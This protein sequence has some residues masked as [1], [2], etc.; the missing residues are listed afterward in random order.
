MTTTVSRPGIGLLTLERGPGDL[1]IWSLQQPVTSSAYRLPIAVNILLNGVDDLDHVDLPMIAHVLDDVDHYLMAGLR[2]VHATMLTDPAWFGLAEDELD[3]YREV[4]AEE[5]PLDNPQ[6]NFY[7]DSE[8]VLH[9]QE[10][11]FA[12]CD[13][14]G[15]AVIFAQHRPIRL[16]DLSD[17][18][19]ID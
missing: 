9:F 1:S 17:A 11:R 16:E 18:E 2:F 14:Y 5:L 12:V 8:W 10:G 7:T 3:P 13:P 4:L 6:L 15:L 19:E